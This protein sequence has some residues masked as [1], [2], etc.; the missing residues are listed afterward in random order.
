MNIIPPCAALALLD[1]SSL[2]DIIHEGDK[3]VPEQQ[4]RLA[5]AKRRVRAMERAE[6]KRRA[7]EALAP[8]VAEL[9]GVMG[10]R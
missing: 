1:R 7:H 10:G 6:K 9:Q 3:H 4:R 2:V 8:L 5:Y